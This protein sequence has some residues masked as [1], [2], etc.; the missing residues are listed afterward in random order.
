MEGETTGLGGRTEKLFPANAVWAK[1]LVQCE[2]GDE[3][4]GKKGPGEQKGGKESAA[5]SCKKS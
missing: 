3:G 5:S 2:G 1:G 4:W